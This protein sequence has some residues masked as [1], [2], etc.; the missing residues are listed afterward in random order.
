MKEKMK[1]EGR[2]CERHFKRE[3]KIDKAAKGE[4]GNATSKP[5]ERKRRKLRDV[6]ARK[7]REGLKAEIAGTA[8]GNSARFGL[9][10]RVDKKENR[11]W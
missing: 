5:Q 11:I 9:Y 6:R 3:S 8:R 1:R 2:N 7:R 4:R 10:P